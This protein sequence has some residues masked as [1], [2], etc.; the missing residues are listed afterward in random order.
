MIGLF[1]LQ[2]ERSTAAP[3]LWTFPPSMAAVCRGRM[4]LGTLFRGVRTAQDYINA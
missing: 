2:E 4:N 1:Y 3:A